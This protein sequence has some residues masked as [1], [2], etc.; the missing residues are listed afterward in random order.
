MDGAVGLSVCKGQSKGIQEAP[1]A[2]AAP[3][4]SYR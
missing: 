4:S 1:N 3:S 2:E